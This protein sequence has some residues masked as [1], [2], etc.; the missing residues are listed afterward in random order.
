MGLVFRAALVVV[1]LAVLGF[2]LLA[3]F[4]RAQDANWTYPPVGRDLHAEL[5]ERVTEAPLNSEDIDM[6]ARARVK[7]APL[8]PLPFEAKLVAE[9]ESGADP[10]RVA[11]LAEAAL[12][13]NARS[14]AARLL[15]FS[16]RAHQ[17]DWPAMLDEFEVLHEL[18]PGQRRDLVQALAGQMTDPSARAAISARITQDAPAW[19]QSLAARL[20]LGDVPLETLITVYRPYPPIQGRLVGELV[21]A[22]DHDSAYLAWV[23]LLDEDVALSSLPFD[24]TFVGLDAP[25]PFNWVIDRR[26]AERLPDGGLYVAYFG[27]ARPRIAFQLL[28][29]TPGTYRLQAMADGDVPD[30]AGDLVWT[31]RCAGGGATLLRHSLARG[32]DAVHAVDDTSWTFD[33][34]GSGCGYQELALTGQPGEYP[35]PIRLTLRS[36]RISAVERAL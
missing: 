28:P 7:S 23:L 27:T 35:Q 32:G 14:R 17:G 34:P 26:T 24:G 30:A 29:L 36:V 33:V 8:A 2:G 6:L 16:L 1:G 20:S 10:A 9:L 12:R 21:R 4:N 5:Q 25:T 3:G 19:G 22:G 15:R 13:R 11:E 31:V 18:L